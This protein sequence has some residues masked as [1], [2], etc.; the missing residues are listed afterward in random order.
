MSH[1]PNKRE[2]TL[3]AFAVLIGVVFSVYL[4]NS[5]YGQSMKSLLNNRN[6]TVE[7]N[8]KYQNTIDRLQ[9]TEPLLDAMAERALP[10]HDRR[11]SSSRYQNWLI[12][13]VKQSQLQNNS[14][15]PMAI[16]DVKKGPD[17]QYCIFSYSVRGRCSLAQASGLLRRF[18][19][20]D[21]LHSITSLSLKPLQNNTSIVDLS[22]EVS[23]IGLP[24]TPPS[25]DLVMKKKETIIAQDEI[26]SIVNRALFTNYAPPRQP[27]VEDTPPPKPPV[28][29]AL[30]IRP[31]CYLNAITD[32]NGIKEAWIDI[33]TNGTRLYV[34]NGDQFMLGTVQVVVLKINE[35]S[36]EVEAG[37]NRIKC[38]IRFGQTFADAELL[39]S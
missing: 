35:D 28:Q 13:I 3:I 19:E 8:K 15:D 24:Q 6:K 37:K 36:I 31:F 22:M 27:I 16:R 9:R 2:K 17:L 25:D 21:Q 30:D 1:G 11:A 38:R 29:A 18:Y 14:V 33:R 5:F 39:E 10:L 12:S 23:A 34:K 4:L 20:V 26:N 7:T 32:I